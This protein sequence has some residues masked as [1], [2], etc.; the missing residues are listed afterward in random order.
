MRPPVL[1]AINPVL[2]A[3][4]TPLGGVP[5]PYKLMPNLQLGQPAQVCWVMYIGVDQRVVRLR[6]MELWSNNRLFPSHT[7][8]LSTASPL[9]AS[10]GAES[11]NTATETT[12]CGRVAYAVL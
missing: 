9:F 3:A 11:S 2:G 6:S 8:A 4:P 10:T 5:D 1:P 12:V 7:I